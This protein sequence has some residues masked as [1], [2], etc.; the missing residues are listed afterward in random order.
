[1]LLAWLLQGACAARTHGAYPA[2]LRTL[3]A[4]CLA[5][6][7]MQLRGAGESGGAVAQTAELYSWKGTLLQAVREEGEVVRLLDLQSCGAVLWERSAHSAGTLSEILASAQRAKRIP[8]F[9]EKKVAP[10]I[11]ASPAPPAKPSPEDIRISDS[12]D[13]EAEDMEVE[14]DAAKLAQ[15]AEDAERRGLTDDELEDVFSAPA[16]AAV[17][18]PQC[19]QDIGMA[20]CLQEA[21]LVHDADDDDAMC[22]ASESSGSTSDNEEG[23][24]VVGDLF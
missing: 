3:V 14:P 4:P 13:E 11:V 20:Y 2:A 23:M 17:A 12:D 5:R 16:P 6:A 1:M 7:P 24:F 21:E 9:L 10:Y 8:A 18:P 15:R 19:E 22:I